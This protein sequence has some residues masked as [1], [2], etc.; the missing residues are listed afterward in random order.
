M[1]EKYN[2]KNL[3]KNWVVLND[4]S[5]NFK[6]YVMSYLNMKRH[7]NNKG[8]LM[9]LSG[10][11]GIIDG[12]VS[13]FKVKSHFS[14]KILTVDQFIY[15]ITI[16]IS[17]IGKDVDCFYNYTNLPGNWA[18]LN[19]DLDK[20][21]C[22]TKVFSYLEQCYKKA[23]KDHQ[24]KMPEK[25]P[26]SYF[27]MIRHSEFYVGILKGIPFFCFTIH[28]INSNGIKILTAEEF[29]TIISTETIISINSLLSKQII[30]LNQNI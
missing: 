5:N 18:V 24:H 10:Y 11:F 3:P 2:Y 30:I 7:I 22:H 28:Q 29:K 16:G 15:L 8:Q 4:E 19:K 6:E 1:V 17:E 27:D 12:T 21:G 25:Y 26:L 14:C 13:C 9:P 20:V 23:G